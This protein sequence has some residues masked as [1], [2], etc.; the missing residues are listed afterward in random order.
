MLLPE[1]WKTQAPGI[2]IQLLGFEHFL[3]R[4]FDVVE[5]V[6]TFFAPV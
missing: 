6:E 4:D 3:L 1:L 5:G 2:S